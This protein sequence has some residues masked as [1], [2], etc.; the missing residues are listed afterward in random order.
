MKKICIFSF[1]LLLIAGIVFF[2][3]CGKNPVGTGS[4]LLSSETGNSTG[5]YKTEE[6]KSSISGNPQNILNSA[7]DILNN[8]QSAM[9]KSGISVGG[10]ISNIKLS[11]KLL[12]F[13]VMPLA[14][15][16]GY[17]GP[18]TGPDGT[19]GWYKYKYDI[20]QSGITLNTTYYLR[21]KPG[22]YYADTNAEVKTIDIWITATGNFNISGNT[23]SFNSFNIKSHI[24]GINSDKI[25]GY[26]NYNG[27]LTYN[28]ASYKW[29]SEWDFEQ[30]IIASDKSG[31]YKFYLTLT[32]PSSSSAYSGNIEFKSDGSGDG[33]IYLNNS[34]FVTI[35]WDAGGKTGYYITSDGKQYN[36]G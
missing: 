3:G 21:T 6:G 28:G 12:P 35:H 34:L 22:D 11:S 33:K 2:Y 10:P 23:G 36:F 13:G 4:G 24:I 26:F 29:N 16:A 32:D 30:S 20:N 15:P 18:T 27:D 25:G 31:K 8:S 9:T 1:V 19:N 5:K 17:I 7:S 14:P